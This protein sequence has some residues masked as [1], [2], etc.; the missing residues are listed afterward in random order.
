[1]STREE[2]KQEL[3]QKLAAQ[4]RNAAGMEDRSAQDDIG[5]AKGGRQADKLDQA[6]DGVRSM[7]AGG[8]ALLVRRFNRQAAE[9]EGLA[10]EGGKEEVIGEGSIFL[11]DGIEYDNDEKFFLI[12]HGAGRRIGKVTAVSPESPVGKAVFGKRKKQ[13]VKILLSDGKQIAAKIK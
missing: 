3:K 12:R 1:M 10:L 2:L 8:H 5:G 11:L 7:S 13:D 4:L 9:L 6:L